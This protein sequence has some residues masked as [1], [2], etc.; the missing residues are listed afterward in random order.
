MPQSIKVMLK[1]NDFF[2]IIT[3][4]IVNLKNRGAQNLGLKRIMDNLSRN[5]SSP[6]EIVDSLNKLANNFLD[7]LGKRK[8]YRS[9]SLN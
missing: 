1:P 5:F 2:V 4:G 7:G 9:S 3:D 8:I 6:M